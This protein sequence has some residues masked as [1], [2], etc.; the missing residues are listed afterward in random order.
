MTNFQAAM[1]VASLEEIEK[2]II[3]KRKIANFYYQKLKNIAGL[4]LPS[5]QKC[6]KSVYW[7][8]AILIDE[9][10]F[11]INRDKLMKILK[12]K[13]NIQTRTFFYPPNK[14][15]KKLS[16]YQNQKFPIAEKIGEQGLYLP[17][18]LGNTIK[19]IREVCQ[20]IIKIKSDLK[21]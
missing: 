17:S 15:F 19:E 9:K 7:M 14:A 10:K 11:G 13:Y 21:K 18:G 3:Y 4:T 2:S 12:E 8:Y 6:A 20:A 5:E 16:L 1:G